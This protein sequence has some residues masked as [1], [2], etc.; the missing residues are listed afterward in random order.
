MPR[1]PA[2]NINKA[3]LVL[4]ALV[5]L[6]MNLRSP[7]TAVP[8]VLQSIRNDLALNATLSGLLTSI[9]V[10]CFGVLTPL[11]SLLIARI[12]INK[13]MWFTLVGT[14]I[15][16]LFRPYTG[17]L[18]MLAG[19]LLLGAALAAGNIVS[20]M[21]IAR[22]FRQRM[23]MV[24]GIYTSSLNIG[25]MLT[26]SLTAPIALFTGWQFALASWVWL[27]LFALVLW[28]YSQRRSVP[29]T[30]ISPEYNPL[31]LQSS[32]PVSGIRKIAI[33][34]LSA[35]FVAHLFIYYGITAWLPSY[36]ITN[37]GMHAATAGGIASIFQGMALL[38]AFGVP[39]LNRYIKSGYLMVAMGVCWGAS[40]LFMSFFPRL[41]P[42]WCFIGGIAQG[43][44]FVV[45]F[46]L[47]MQL[48]PDLDDN[49]RISAMV[50]G[51]GYTLASLGPIVVGQFHEMS[52]QW[53]HSWECLTGVSV[54]MILSGVIIITIVD[55]TTSRIERP[56]EDGQR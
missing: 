3:L 36:L 12:G 56:V 34:A 31:P 29:A 38:G 4:F 46:T 6:G 13:S 30:S 54:I 1:I 48:S 18:G 39:V 40:I 5:V 26:S 20:L 42:V 43:G 32:H 45:I 28:L 41:W 14:A 7:L 52:G 15:G 2:V 47:I 22:D 23:S 9:P 35:G 25:T 44:G 24:T 19:T 37:G 11:A 10:L 55:K 49:R 50:Q 53:R 8:P 33:A 27:P 51:I 21:I 16:I 17:T